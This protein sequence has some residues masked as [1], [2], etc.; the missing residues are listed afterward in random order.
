MRTQL[1][2]PQDFEERF[3]GKEDL[4]RLDQVAKEVKE[5]GSV[6]DRDASRFWER[7]SV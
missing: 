6:V 4:Q 3:I 1:A 5:L 7:D 2:E